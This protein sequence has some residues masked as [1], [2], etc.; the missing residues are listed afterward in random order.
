MHED[1][2]SLLAIADIYS[3]WLGWSVVMS[4]GTKFNFMKKSI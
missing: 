2:H 4:L 3:C 1:F